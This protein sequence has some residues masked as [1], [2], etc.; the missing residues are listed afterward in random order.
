M[1]RIYATVV[2]LGIHKF[3]QV[4]VEHWDIYY[5][6]F[7]TRKGEEKMENMSICAK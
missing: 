2:F 4:E 6:L 3:L 7:K 1:G 5:S